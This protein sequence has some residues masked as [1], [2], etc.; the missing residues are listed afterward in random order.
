MERTII[1]RNGKHHKILLDPDSAA[2]TMA[3][4]AAAKYFAVTHNGKRV[5]LHRFLMNAA[6]GDV[7][8]HINR[9]ICDNRLCNLRK[10][11]KAQNAY[12]MGLVKT[13]TSG[14]MGVSFCNGKGRQKKPWTA[15]IKMNNKRIHIGSYATVEE[16]V[17]A[18]DMTCH[19]LR[20]D[21][22]VLNN[23]DSVFKNRMDLL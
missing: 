16:A 11:T 10:V 7:I 1:L 20:G 5:H 17:L 13:N 3:I 19:N 15:G 14:Y 22:A 21:F 4:T 2:K 12:N 18:Y 9:D 23:P 8:D 6:E